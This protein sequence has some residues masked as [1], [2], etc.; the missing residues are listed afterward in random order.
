MTC[1]REAGIILIVLINQPFGDERLVSTFLTNQI[2]MQQKIESSVEYLYALQEITLQCFV[3]IRDEILTD[4]DTFSIYDLL[5]DRAHEF[6]AQNNRDD[7]AVSYYER[8][9]NF[10]KSKIEKLKE[11]SYF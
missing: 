10:L 9:D 1:R 3:E 2:I 5:Q 4:T 11:N 6:C 8:I 7:D